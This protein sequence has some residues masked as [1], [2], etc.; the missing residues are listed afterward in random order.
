MRGI[1]KFVLVPSLAVMMIL[2]VISAVQAGAFWRLGAKKADF[3]SL[4]GRLPVFSPL[5]AGGAG[6]ERL[7]GK[8]DPKHWQPTGNRI[9]QG[10]S[11]TCL[12]RWSTWEITT[13][14]T[15]EILEVAVLE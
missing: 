3:S 2:L 11:I 10:R 13:F 15:R 5:L 9:Q 4:G 8:S 1:M 14:T 7:L 6:E 12:Q